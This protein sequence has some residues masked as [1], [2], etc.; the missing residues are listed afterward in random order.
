[1]SYIEVINDL[2]ASIIRCKT[3]GEEIDHEMIF[4]PV[5]WAD[6]DVSNGYFKWLVANKVATRAEINAKR[7]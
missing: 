6:A 4:A 5:N 7:W 1:M 2:K 3:A